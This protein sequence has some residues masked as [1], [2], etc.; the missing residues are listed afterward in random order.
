MYRIEIEEI[1]KLIGTSGAFLD[2]GCAVGKFLKLLP[3][4]FE[5]WAPNFQRAP[6]R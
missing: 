5:K 2:V 4:T 6:P 1:K 3:D